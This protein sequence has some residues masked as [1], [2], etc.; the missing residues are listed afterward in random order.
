MRVRLLQAAW[1]SAKESSILLQFTD[2]YIFIKEWNKKQWTL[3][4]LH[5]TKQIK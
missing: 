3:I 1:I 4:K 2:D 5:G